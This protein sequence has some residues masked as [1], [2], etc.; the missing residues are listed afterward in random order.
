MGASSNVY[1]ETVNPPSHSVG[2]TVKAKGRYGTQ[3]VTAIQRNGV[4]PTDGNDGHAYSVQG[5]KGGRTTIHGSSELAAFQL[6][7]T[8][9][10]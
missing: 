10:P 6:G 4:P 9:A 7:E 3:T 2:D 8:E 5:G 1:G